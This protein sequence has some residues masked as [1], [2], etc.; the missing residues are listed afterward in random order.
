MT[1][2]EQRRKKKQKDYEPKSCEWCAEEFKPR[3]ENQKYCDAG[4]RYAAWFD[5]TYERKVK[6]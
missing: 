6:Q 5:R 3:R 2:Y 4:C 1:D